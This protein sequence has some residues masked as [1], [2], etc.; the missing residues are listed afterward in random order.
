MGGIT[1]IVGP[2]PDRARF[3]RMRRAI[4]GRGEAE[5]I[6]TLSGVLAGNAGRRRRP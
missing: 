1:A 6:T 5:V 2:H 4:A 3:D